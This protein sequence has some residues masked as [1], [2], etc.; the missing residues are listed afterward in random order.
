MVDS[1]ADQ[2]VL[3]YRMRELASP[4]PAHQPVRKL[5][6]KKFCLLMAFSL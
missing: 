5:I 4:S 6:P 3:K 1:F 2:S